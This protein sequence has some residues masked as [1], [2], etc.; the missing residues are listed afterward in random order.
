MKSKKREQIVRLALIIVFLLGIVFVLVGMNQSDP[1]VTI[2]M[3]VGCSL[4]AT[5]LSSFVLLQ[6]DTQNEIL[7]VL[8]KIESSVDDLLK[9]EYTLRALKEVGINTGFI[10]EQIQKLTKAALQ[11]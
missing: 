8:T 7:E 3:S 9:P 5:G 2:F 6:D 10:N 1:F 4:L 11:M